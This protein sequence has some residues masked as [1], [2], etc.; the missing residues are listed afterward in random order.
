MPEHYKFVGE[1]GVDCDVPLGRIVRF[2]P[3]LRLD[4]D[5][6]TGLWRD[7]YSGDPR[8]QVFEHSSLIPYRAKFKTFDLVT[9]KEGSQTGKKL[10]ISHFFCNLR[11]GEWIYTLNTGTER[12]ESELV[13]VPETPMV[14][15][16]VVE[17]RDN[18]TKWVDY[19]TT[20]GGD[21][22]TDYASAMRSY[23]AAQVYGNWGPIRDPFRA[24]QA[25]QPIQAGDAV[26]VNGVTGRAVPAN[27]MVGRVVRMLAYYPDSGFNTN[28][29]SHPILWRPE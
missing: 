5:S 15:P 19:A 11:T 10:A 6:S 1:D 27:Q 26:S 24:V 7:P 12:Q 2:E 23:H 28:S 20:Y 17:K 3:G 8:S 9:L 29:Y 22:S 18:L 13:G 14:Q 25:G 21:F 16:N 4:R